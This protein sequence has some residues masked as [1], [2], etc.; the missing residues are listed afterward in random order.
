[1]REV[2][3]FVVR[4][5]GIRPL[6]M[7]NPEAIELESKRKGKK[8]DPKEEAEHRLYKDPN[9]IICV[10]A[11]NIKACIRD[12]AKEYKVPGKG[13]KTFKDYI[14]AGIIIEPEFVPIITNGVDPEKAWKIDKS[15]VV[16][17]GSRILRARPRFDNWEL[18]FTVKIIDPIIRPE[19]LK[20]F[21]ET[22]GK[23]VGLC[24]YRP[25]YGLFEVIK[26]EKRNNANKS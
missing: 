26:F 4:I 8:L 12:A 20:E 23:Y 18:E 19:N 25:E 5:R 24:D 6:L 3:E 15:F 10:P 9:G 21:L 2:E 13:K 22:A 16:V 7:N 17:Q 11:R 14:K 1:M